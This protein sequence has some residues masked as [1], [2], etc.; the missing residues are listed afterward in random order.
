MDEFKVGEVVRSK[1]GGP[2]M[3]VTKVEKDLAGGRIVCV[4]AC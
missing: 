4:D 3:T 2:M 1:A